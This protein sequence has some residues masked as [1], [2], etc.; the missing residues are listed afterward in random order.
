MWLVT[1]FINKIKIKLSETWVE[2]GCVWAKQGQ[3]CRGHT[4]G[5]HESPKSEM[6]NVYGHAVSNIL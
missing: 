2:I 1:Q 5:V 4:G 6:K 3:T